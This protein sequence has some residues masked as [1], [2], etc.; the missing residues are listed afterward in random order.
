MYEEQMGHTFE[1]QILIVPVGHLTCNKS[2]EVR[3][4]SILLLSI[5]A[6][7]THNTAATLYQILHAINIFR[8]LN[9]VKQ[10]FVEDLIVWEF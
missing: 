6:H 8:F 1:R 9:Y 3:E 5:S 2:L 7:M 10:Y 4:N